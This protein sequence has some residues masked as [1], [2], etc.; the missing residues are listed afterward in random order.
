MV[1]RAEV[2]DRF[3]GELLTR[4]RHKKEKKKAAKALAD[5][6]KATEAGKATKAG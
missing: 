3:A 6:G 5:A 2:F 1:K 4:I